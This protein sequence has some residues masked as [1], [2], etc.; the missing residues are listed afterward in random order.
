MQD[1]GQNGGITGLIDLVNAA[2]TTAKFRGRMFVASQSIH[3]GETD[4][5]GRGD[6]DFPDQAYTFSDGLFKIDGIADSLAYTA[7]NN[8][9]GETG[10]I[11][12]QISARS[13]VSYPVRVTGQTLERDE[14]IEQQTNLVLSGRITMFPTFTV[15]GVAQPTAGN[16]N[17]S[18]KALWSGMV[19]HVDTGPN[20]LQGAG[21]QLW[22]V[23]GLSDNDAA[24]VT[25]ITALVTAYAASVSGLVLK[26]ADLKRISARL[27]RISFTE[28]LTTTTDDV[29]IATTEVFVDPNLLGNHAE[30]SA[31]NGTASVPSNMTEEGVSQKLLPGGNAQNILVAGRQSSIQKIEQPGSFVTTDAI[32]INVD[33]DVTKVFDTGTPPSNPSLG[34]NQVINNYVD[35]QVDMSKSKRVFHIRGVTTEQEQ[36]F[37]HNK[38]TVD[39]ASD[40]LQSETVIAKLWPVGT[41]PSDPTPGTG[42]KI[43]QH[44]DIPVQTNAGFMVRVWILRTKDSNDEVIF[45]KRKN[46]IDPNAINS[47][48]VDAAVYTTGSPPSDPTPPTGMKIV[49]KTEVTLNITYSVIVWEMGLR[50]SKDEIELGAP[51][52]SHFHGGTFATYSPV[53]TRQWNT[54]TVESCVATDT[55]QTLA[56]ARFIS[57]ATGTTGDVS[58]LDVSCKKLNSGKAI[59]TVALGPKLCLMKGQSY[60]GFDR[61]K[62][63]VSGGN[64]QVWCADVVTRGGYDHVLITPQ[65]VLRQRTRF[66]I[67]RKVMTDSSGDFDQKFSYMGTS[68]GSSFLGYPSSTVAYRGCGFVYNVELF[69]ILTGASLAKEF[70][71][72]QH[73]D[74]EYRSDGA[75]DEAGVVMGWFVVSTGTVTKNAWN[76]AS[77]LSWSAALLTGA[78]YSVFL[79]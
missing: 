74:F 25:G 79:P 53:N 15:D 60:G 59:Y 52:S 14:K 36:E 56:M 48:F 69:N 70:P 63:R 46:V 55:A 21:S 37:Q 38:V 40:P 12:Y 23:W 29:N 28:S 39:T 47:T 41:P 20:N 65:T 10:T 44:F 26:F 64:V 35:Q 62:T 50:D 19:K 54:V 57:T 17:G 9:I 42:L 73:F 13:R 30:I 76:D 6:G 16:P 18:T 77:L 3:A 24:E 51:T 67:V 71:M 32:G 11:S 34:T 4:N 7:P 43:A 75:V 68:N 33:E 27:C 72:P 49:T 45:D 78:D 8:W 22:S 61:V 31:V 66:S 2:G 5:A 1:T 58:T